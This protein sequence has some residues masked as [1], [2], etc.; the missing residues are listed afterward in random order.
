MN[1]LIHEHPSAEVRSAAIRL[2]DVLCTWE[3]N[4]G[5]KN[6]VIIKEGTDYDYRTLSNSP[7][8]S[9]VTDAHLLEAFGNM[10]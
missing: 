4:T 3:R 6:L 10:P 1:N 2:L 5:R 8:P 7:V 9:D